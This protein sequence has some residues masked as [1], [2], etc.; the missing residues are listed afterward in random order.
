MSANEFLTRVNLMKGYRF[1]DYDTPVKVGPHV[2]VVGAGNVAMD[3]ARSALRLQHDVCARLADEN[4]HAGEVHIVYRRSRAEVPAREEE[5]H[6]AG[7]GR[8]HLRLPHQPIEILG[9]EKG[10]VRGMRCIRMEL[11]EPDASGRRSP[12]PI[13]GSEFEMPVDTVI[14]ALGTSPNPIVFTDA[15]GLQR[16]KHGTVV[17]DDRDGPDQQAGRL[18][19]RRRRHRRGDGHQRDGRGKAGRCGHARS[20]ATRTST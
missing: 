12:V 4:G 2:A 16:T 6:H 17:A 9:D 20:S 1:P 18:G 7:R 15:Q 5:F 10:N 11:G 14:F 19:R 8:R 13:E 3:A